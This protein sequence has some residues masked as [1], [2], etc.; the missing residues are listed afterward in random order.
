ML[1]GRS[2][3]TLRCTPGHDLDACSLFTQ[4]QMSTRWKQL[5]EETKKGAGY[6]IDKGRN[7]KLCSIMGSSMRRGGWEVVVP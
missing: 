6:V 7:F 3:F 1:C 4:Q 5:G 2:M